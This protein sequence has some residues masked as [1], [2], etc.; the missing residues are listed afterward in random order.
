MPRCASI[1][2]R[3]GVSM[4]TTSARLAAALWL[5]KQALEDEHRHRWTQHDEDW[6]ISVLLD[7]ISRDDLINGWSCPE[8]IAVYICAM[9]RHS[10]NNM[11]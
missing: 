5:A 7:P 3:S 9:F 2:A 6:Y 4:R 1:Q 11:D 8:D 10:T